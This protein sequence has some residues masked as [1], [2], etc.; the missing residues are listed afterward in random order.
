[1]TDAV[2][3][4]AFEEGNTRLWIDESIAIERPHVGLRH[5][6]RVA[7]DELQMWIG[8]DGRGRIRADRSDVDALMNG[9]EQTRE[10]LGALIHEGDYIVGESGD[11]VI[12][13]IWSLIGRL[14]RSISQSMTR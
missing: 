3:Y 12:W 9:F 14:S 8:S 5:F 4:E 13:V 10:R 2:G 7:E 6:A 1:M 11:L